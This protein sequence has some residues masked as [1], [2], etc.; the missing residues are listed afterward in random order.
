LPTTNRWKGRGN[1]KRERTFTLA[2]PAVLRLNLDKA[3]SNVTSEFR[4]E[5]KVT[6][7]Q[8]GQRK[9]EIARKGRQ[10]FVGE[11]EIDKKSSTSH[12]TKRLQ[13]PKKKE[14]IRRRMVVCFKNLEEEE[15]DDLS[16][17][18]LQKKKDHSRIPR[19]NLHLYRSTGTSGIGGRQSSVGRMTGKEADRHWNGIMRDTILAYLIKSG[20]RKSPHPVVVAKLKRLIRHDGGESQRWIP[21]K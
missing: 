8:Y 5:G 11:S 13:K 20:E 4:K 14:S 18:T 3:P 9:A 6:L 2:P 19:V 16:G 12:S 7:G 1:K 21:L 17:Q 15:K 10:V